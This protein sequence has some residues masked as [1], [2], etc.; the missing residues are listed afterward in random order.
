MSASAGDRRSVSGYSDASDMQQDDAYLQRVYDSLRT[1]LPAWAQDAT[2]DVH[3]YPSLT[4]TYTIEKH[5]IFVRVRDDKGV[6][7]PEC[8]LRHVMLH[9]LAHVLNT[10][11]TGHD[12]AFRA[13]MKRLLSAEV[14]ASRPG[15]SL[16]RKPLAGSRR[17]VPTRCR[18][19]TI[20]A[21]CCPGP[22]ALVHPDRFFSF[23]CPP[24]LCVAA[25]PRPPSPPRR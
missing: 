4:C 13:M 8:V 17:P 5:R 1:L 11:S 6:R 19:S 23:F 18:R 2:A 16:K 7:F 20:R 21:P 15:F 12:E 10:R 24:P 3:A 9:E 22:V 25:P 14:S